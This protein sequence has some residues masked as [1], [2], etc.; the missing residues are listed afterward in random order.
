[1]NNYVLDL[2]MNIRQLDDGSFIATGRDLPILVKAKD[3]E[4][5]REKLASVSVSIQRYL[6]RLGDAEAQAFLAERGVKPT[7][8]S[9]ET[10]QFSM[11]V[12][13]SA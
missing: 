2:R 7:R 9:A 1:M 5:L 13:L 10:D 3:M 6:E 8:V 12:L 4:R 11:P